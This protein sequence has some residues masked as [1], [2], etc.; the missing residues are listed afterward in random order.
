[1]QSSLL[2]FSSSAHFLPS[3]CACLLSHVTYTSNKL[4]WITPV[5]FIYLS[6]WSHTCRHYCSVIRCKHI[7]MILCHIR[8]NNSLIGMIGILLVLNC[9]IL[10]SNRVNSF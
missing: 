6:L 2:L 4:P 1:M 3:L 7:C 5:H 8:A 10:P 9:T